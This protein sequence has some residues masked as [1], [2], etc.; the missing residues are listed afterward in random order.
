[1][2]RKELIPQCDIK[3]QEGEKKTVC[4]QSRENNKSVDFGFRFMDLMPSLELE[5]ELLGH[6]QVMSER[7]DCGGG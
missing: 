1:M 6:H 7:R 2:R 4:D 5:L 3:T